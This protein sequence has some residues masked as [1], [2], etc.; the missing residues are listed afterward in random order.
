M[1]VLFLL[2]VHA[3]KMSSSFEPENHAKKS[4]DAASSLGKSDGT[5]KAQSSSNKSLLQHGFLLP[6][7]RPSQPQASQCPQLVSGS[8]SNSDSEPDT[9]GDSCSDSSDFDLAHV[10][11][12]A[13]SLGFKRVSPKRY[14]SL[15]NIILFFIKFD[16]IFERN[17]WQKPLHYGQISSESLF[18]K[19]WSGG[20]FQ[21]WQMITQIVTQ[22]EPDFGSFNQIF[23][24]VYSILWTMFFVSCSLGEF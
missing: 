9:D 22:M 16:V 14:L 10:E 23:S 8:D 4:T 7:S 18:F 17:L 15:I 11:A 24:T 3:T 1:C 12:L 19:A 20:L 6:R 13:Q 21:D 5:G 2:I